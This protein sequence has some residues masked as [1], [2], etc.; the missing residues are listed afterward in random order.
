M[1]SDDG[2][3]TGFSETNLHIKRSTTAA[4]NEGFIFLFDDDYQA[5]NIQAMRSATI[6]SNAVTPVT[7]A[8]FLESAHNSINHWERAALIVSMNIAQAADNICKFHEVHVQQLVQILDI[9]TKYNV[10]LDGRL[11]FLTVQR[12]WPHVTLVLTGEKYS[13][14]SRHE[15]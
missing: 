15:Y 3:E 13:T 10:T 9:C 12:D 6:A 7:P 14:E 8:S 4:N 5:P 2:G 1:C 11:L